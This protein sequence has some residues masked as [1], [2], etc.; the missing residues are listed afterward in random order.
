MKTKLGRLVDHDPRSVNYPVA[1]KPVSSLRTVRWKRRIPILDQEDLRSQGIEVDGDA[2]ALG[3]CTGNA[4]TGWVGTDN[5]KRAGITTYSGMPVDEVFAIEVYSD[6]T[7]LDGISGNS[8]PREDQGSSG[9]G[10]TKALKKRHLVGSYKHCFS[11]QAIATA[12]QDGPVL[13]GIEWVEAMFDANPHNGS[14][15]LRGEVAGGHEICIE[16]FD[17]SDREFLIANSWTT[18]YGLKGYFVLTFDQ[19]QDRMD[20]QGDAV[21]PVAS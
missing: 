15:E 17:A 2:D 16:G 4:A 21:A 6:A 12:L 20:H 19:L 8:W 9:L 3:S 11:A 5:A 7:R 13:L 18:S 1:G 14:V 10:A